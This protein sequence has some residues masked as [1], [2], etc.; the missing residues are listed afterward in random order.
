[1]KARSVTPTVPAAAEAWARS[2]PNDLHS[3]AVPTATVGL[4]PLTRDPRNPAEDQNLQTFR[5]EGYNSSILVP[6]SIFPAPPERSDSQRT[7][8][9]STDRKTKLD[10]FVEPQHLV[11]ISQVFR[12]FIAAG[13]LQPHYQ[14]VKANWFVVSGD[15]NGRGYYV[16]CVAKDNLLFYMALDYD[17]ETCPISE[18]TFTAMSRSFLGK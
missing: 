1:R 5:L 16:K 6:K 7:T 14:T 9:G 13:N 11:P 8:F 12:S 17:E 18:T 10:V 15:K 4:E 3:A 2:R